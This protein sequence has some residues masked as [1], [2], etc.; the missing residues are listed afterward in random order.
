VICFYDFAATATGMVARLIANVEIHGQ[1]NFP[2]KGPVIVAPN[3][4]HLADPPILASA[5]PRKIHFMVKEEAWNTLIFGRICRWF[6]A[7]PVARGSA[8]LTAYRASLR[9][10]SQDRVIGI[11]PEGHRS[12]DGYLQKGNAGA[13]VIARRARAP[14]V[15]VG[16]FGV[17]QAIKHPGIISRR[18]IRINVGE[19]FYPFKEGSRNVAD[20]TGELMERIAAL[21][22]A[23]MRRPADVVVSQP[24]VDHE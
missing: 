11:F 4:Q 16:I 13:V 12:P 20:E 19:P 18:T 23:E 3:H 10:L 1:E 9:I 5:L 6:E 21:L 2:L 7:F 8:D 22:P 24:S 15:P 14:I 17:S